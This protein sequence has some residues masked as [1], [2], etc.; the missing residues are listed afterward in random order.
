MSVF[1]NLSQLLPEQLCEEIGL[2]RY[3]MKK[4]SC[5]L[6]IS[7]TMKFFLRWLS[8]DTSRKSNQIQIYVFS[9]GVFKCK[10]IEWSVTVIVYVGSVREKS[11]SL[12]VIPHP[13]Q[14]DM[15]RCSTASPPGVK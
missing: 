8:F 7:R 5:F 11:Y 14:T 3:K 13:F 4:M 9:Q 1:F 2:L 10:S 6:K 12:N 15:Y